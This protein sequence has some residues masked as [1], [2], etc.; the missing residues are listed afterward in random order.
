[1]YP[2]KRSN[3]F[4]DNRA[5]LELLATTNPTQR[6]QLVRTA[7]QDQLK[8]ICEC[9]YNTLKRN[10]PLSP[11]Q[12]NTLRKHKG[13]VYKL[14]DKGIPLTRKRKLLEQSGGF[15][16]ALLAPI[17]GTAIGAIADTVIRK[18]V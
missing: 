18:Y 16:P 14:V 13:I 15:L 12:I 5:F 11:R 7:T 17:L 3:R 9:A 2:V 6:N 8:S 4:G 1:M 10:V